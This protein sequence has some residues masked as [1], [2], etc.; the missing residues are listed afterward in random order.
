M[1]ENTENMVATMAS[2][3]KEENGDQKERGESSY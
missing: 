2:K 3:Q 1:E